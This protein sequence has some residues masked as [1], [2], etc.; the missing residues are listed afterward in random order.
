[1]RECSHGKNVHTH[2][3]ECREATHN[4][5]DREVEDVRRCKAN[6]A[7]HCRATGRHTNDTCSHVR[8]G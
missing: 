7:A 6:H 2:C 8:R 1:M 3:A 4:D 5:H